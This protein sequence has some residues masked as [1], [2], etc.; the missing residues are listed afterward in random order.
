MTPTWGGVW[1]AP[2]TM[3]DAAGA[4]DEEA[5]AGHFEWLI[6]QGVDGLVIGGTSAE[7][8]GMTDAERRRIT[9]LAVGSAAGRV[10]IL[11]GTGSYGTAATIGLTEHAA[12]AGADGAL[13]VLPFFQRPSRAEVLAHYRAV[14]S[15]VDLPLFVYN[16]PANAAAP[17]VS[18]ADL[19]ELYR[20]GVISGVKNTGPL[21]QQVN[22]LRATVDE[23]FRVFYGGLAAPL[24][25]AAGGAHGWVSGLLN[26]IASDAVTLW[27]A[28]TDGDFASARDIWTRQLVYRQ[29]VAAPVVPGASDLAIYRGLLRLSGRPAG[30]CRAPLRDLD[31]QGMRALEKVVACAGTDGAARTVGRPVLEGQVS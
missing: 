18:V 24:E 29:L 20:D 7:F 22:E 3:F 1:P 11:A 10:P 28:A 13:V 30:Y 6:S 17:A 2:L 9:E 12:A 14:G 19:G 25:A 27:A 4:V 23:G 15:A 31:D 8:V 26:V 21:V 5:T 16:I